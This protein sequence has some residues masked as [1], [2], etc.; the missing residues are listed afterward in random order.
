MGHFNF[1]VVFV[2]VFFCICCTGIRGMWW[3][4]FSESSNWGLKTGGGS[5]LPTGQYQAERGEGGFCFG[6]PISICSVLFFVHLK[7][8]RKCGSQRPTRQ[9][10]TEGDVV[11]EFCFAVLYS[12][13]NSTWTLG[14]PLLKVI[15][16]T[17]FAVCSITFVFIF[18]RPL[19]LIFYFYLN[20]ANGQRRLS[21]QTCMSQGPSIYYVVQIWGPS[22]PLPP[23]VIL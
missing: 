23:I 7:I 13:D 14:G 21:P 17:Y 5:P 8:K 16:K 10:Q 11:A 19:I 15:W 4:T 1:L 6:I 12:K 9:S 2:F 20:Q 22:R 18:F 3:W